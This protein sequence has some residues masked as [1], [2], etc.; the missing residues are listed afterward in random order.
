M[1]Q[2]QINRERHYYFNYIMKKQ[3]QDKDKLCTLAERFN[4]TEDTPI[5][6]NKILKEKFWDLL[7]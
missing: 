2:Y 6:F 7:A 3:K 4:N 1:K 5:E